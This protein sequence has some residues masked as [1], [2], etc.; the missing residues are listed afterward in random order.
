MCIPDTANPTTS[1]KCI[2]AFKKPVSI[3]EPLKSSELVNCF[4]ESSTSGDYYGFGALSCSHGDNTN[5]YCNQA[6]GDNTALIT[7]Y[8][9]ILG[10]D[11]DK[12]HYLRQRDAFCW[13]DNFDAKSAEHDKFNTWFQLDQRFINYPDRKSVV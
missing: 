5:A 9:D 2:D 12:C 13:H 6:I 10:L 8:K 4:A 3:V 7:A 11:K 1:L